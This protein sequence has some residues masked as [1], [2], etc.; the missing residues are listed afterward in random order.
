MQNL[1]EECLK[2][3]LTINEYKTKFLSTNSLIKIEFEEFEFEV[4]DNVKYLG[5]I[6]QVNESFDKRIVERKKV[7]GMLNS[8]L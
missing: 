6:V 1:N 4:I 5:S 3:G 7:I 8:V 2:W